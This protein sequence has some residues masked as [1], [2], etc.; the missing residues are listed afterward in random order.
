MENSAISWS[1]FV[2]LGTFSVEGVLIGPPLPRNLFP[3]IGSEVHNTCHFIGEKGQPP[4][5]VKFQKKKK[6]TQNW[7]DIA[8]TERVYQTNATH[9][10]KT[11][12]TLNIK[13]VTSEDDTWTYSCEDLPIAGVVPNHTVSFAETV[14]FYCSLTHKNNEAK[15][16]IERA[17][18][19]KNGIP[20]MSTND[21]TQPL[22]VGNVTGRDGG[23]YACLLSVKFYQEQ[24][25]SI[26]PVSNA[27]LHV[28]ARFPTN[29][30]K[31]DAR[32]GEDIAL[33]CS[34]EGYP[35]N[36]TWKKSKS[37]LS[38]VIKATDR[39]K[40][41][42]QCLYCPSIL[43]IQNF[44]VEDY[45]EYSCSALGFPGKQVFHV[46]F[47]GDQA[48]TPSTVTTAVSPAAGTTAISSSAS[49]LAASFFAFLKIWGT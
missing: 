26:T 27:Y 37:G 7:M 5:W 11:S 14:N 32:V 43:F 13:N 41:E 20:L 30:S 39:F 35:L 44:S 4:L 15:V 2:F 23:N 8:N 47:K 17:T 3:F 12:V 10:D 49:Y 25:Y 40:L 46:V 45:G 33:N 34:A 19:I 6:E 21:L 22:V 28:R 31:V 9:G 36:I 29:E 48:S 16:T 42:Q 24:T 38:S 18:F 1:L